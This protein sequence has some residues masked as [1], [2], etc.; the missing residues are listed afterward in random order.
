MIFANALSRIKTF[1]RPAR[2]SNASTALLVP[3]IATF[4]C[5]SSSA[6]GNRI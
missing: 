4:L 5:H 6:L 1:L 3:L 2:L